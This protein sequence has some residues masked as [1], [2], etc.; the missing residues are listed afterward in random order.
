VCFKKELC[1]FICKKIS[2]I[3]VDGVGETEEKAMSKYYAGVTEE[4]VNLSVNLSLIV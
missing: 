1:E 2:G 3:D 4:K